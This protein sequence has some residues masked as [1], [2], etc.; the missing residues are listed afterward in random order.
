MVDIPDVMVNTTDASFQAD[1]FE[2]SQ[3]GLVLVDFWAE[4]CAPCRLLGPIL[5]K[6]AVEFSGRF[7][8]V[9]ANTE[10]AGEAAGQFGVTGIPAVFAVLHGEVIDS[11]QGALPEDS[12][13]TWIENHLNAELLSEASRLVTRDPAV[14][15]AKAREH[16]AAYPN[17]STAMIVL[18]ESMLEQGR[19]AECQEILEKLEDR[20]F[21]ETEAERVKAALELKR[22]ASVDV[23]AARRAAEAD[24][25]NFELQLELAGALAGRQQYVEAFE[26]CL[27]LVA[28]D[29]K[30]TGEKARELMVEVFRVLPEGSE[31]TSDYRRQLS[32]ALY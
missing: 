18:A 4:W 6:L 10:Q 21:L 25:G 32:S 19:E 26:I 28:K 22:R 30:Q 13:R 3:T 17:D 5:E 8:L 27:G 12:I 24:P 31:L 7:C 15:E 23:D 11:F 29:R 14:A 16:L 1:V 2:K 9:K 20:G